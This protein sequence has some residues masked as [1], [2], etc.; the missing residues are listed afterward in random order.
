MVVYQCQDSFDG[1]LCGVY[2]AWMSRLG[3]ENVRLELADVG[4]LFMFTDYHKVEVSECKRDKVISSIREKIGVEVYRQVYQA[5]LSMDQEKAD[6]I[7]RYLIDAFQYGAGVVDM[8]QLPAVFEIFQI[9]RSV[10]NEV[11]ALMG[12]VRFSEIEGG[13]LLSCIEP[14]NDVVTLL[15]PHFADRLSSEKWIIYDENRQKAVVHSLDGRWM[16][17]NVD[18]SEWKDKLDRDANEEVYVA[19]WKVFHRGITIGERT[20]LLCQ[21]GHM[22][23]RYRSHMTEFEP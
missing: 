10:G 9:C 4:N 8:M 11:H 14:K 16:V 7:Y 5:S 3:H 21:R 23:F 12:F 2:D 20:N 22:P 18:D 19:L 1:I 6:K 15:A 13:I 17:V